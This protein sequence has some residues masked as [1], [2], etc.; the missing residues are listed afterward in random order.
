M[1]NAK[2]NGA[3]KK[4]PNMKKLLMGI[5]SGNADLVKLQLVDTLGAGDDQIAALAGDGSVI[6]GDR[7]I[8]CLDVMEEQIKA[9]K[10]N[11]GIFYGAAHFPDMEVRLRK[12]GFKK[13][14][15]VWNTAWSVDK[16][17]AEGRKNK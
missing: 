17:K 2:N 14:K 12:M 3:M 15:H 13:T 16:A 5:M 11:I 4:Q 1:K 10:K 7:N 6:I 9:R 8:K